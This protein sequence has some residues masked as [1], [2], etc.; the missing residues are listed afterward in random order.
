MKIETRE[1]KPNH[2]FITTE[3]IQKIKFITT[4]LYL[5]FSQGPSIKNEQIQIKT[6]KYKERQKP[7]HTDT[8]FVYFRAKQRDRVRID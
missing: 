1:E 8:F 5:S 7:I 3:Y 6:K 4:D 2:K